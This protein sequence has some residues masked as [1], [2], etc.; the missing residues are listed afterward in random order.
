[1]TNQPYLQLL[2]TIRLVLLQLGADKIQV[3]SLKAK[4]GRATI[5]VMPDDRLLAT[6][7]KEGF[8]YYVDQ[9]INVIWRSP[10]VAS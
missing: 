10:E 3:L 8:S 5:E 4:D 7:E 1:M 9:G 6:G 2:N